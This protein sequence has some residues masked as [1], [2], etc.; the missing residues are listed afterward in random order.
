MAGSS[1]IKPGDDE[2]IFDITNALSTCPRR[3]A[4]PRTDHNQTPRPAA[5][6]NRPLGLIFPATDQ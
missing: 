5:L 4:H 3:T 6:G 2:E 1:Q